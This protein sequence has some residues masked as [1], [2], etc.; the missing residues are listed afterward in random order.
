MDKRTEGGH[1]QTEG[2]KA[3]IVGQVWREDMNRRKEGGYGEEKEGRE[4]K[5]GVDC[6]RMQCFIS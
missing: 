2:W 5:L 6:R 3:G 1:G 4:E